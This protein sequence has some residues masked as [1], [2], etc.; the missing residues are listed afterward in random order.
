MQNGKVHRYRGVTMSPRAKTGARLQGPCVELDCHHT[1]FIIVD[2][3]L[4]GA[5]DLRT[6]LESYISSQDVSQQGQMPSL[7]A[8]QPMWPP[9]DPEANPVA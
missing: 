3:P 1:H 4:E 2:G 7:A 8:Q 5:K 9:T 6:Q